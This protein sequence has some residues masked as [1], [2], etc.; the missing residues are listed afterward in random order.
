MFTTVPEMNNSTDSKFP[1]LQSTQMEAEKMHALAELWVGYREQLEESREPR[2]TRQDILSIAAKN[3]N[4]LSLQ[5][6]L[7]AYTYEM[8]AIVVSVAEW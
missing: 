5:S 2:L 7:V 1:G 6:E 3:S 4:D 8:E